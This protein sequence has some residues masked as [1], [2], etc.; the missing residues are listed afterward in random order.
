[1]HSKRAD[2][3]FEWASNPH[4]KSWRAALCEW[5][6]QH[7]SRIAGIKVGNVI[8]DRVGAMGDNPPS[9]EAY[10]RRSHTCTPPLHTTKRK[11]EGGLAFTRAVSSFFDWYLDTKLPELDD[12]GRPIWS[13]EHWNPVPKVRGQVRQTQTAREALPVRLIRQLLE[14]LTADDWRWAK[15]LKKDWITATDATTGEKVELWCP[16]RACALALKLLLPL[17]TFQ[18]RMLESSEGDSEQYRS[19]KWITNRSRHAPPTGRRNCVRRGFLRAFRNRHA[20]GEYTGFFVNTNKTANRIPDQA[21]AGYEIPWQHDHAIQIVEQLERWQ[22]RYNPVDQPLAWSALHEPLVRLATHP[23]P[24][25]AFFL[26]RDPNGTH[27]NEPVTDGRV[28]MLWNA[29]MAKCEDDLAQR[30]ER[31]PDG[32]P[33][34]LTE[35]RQ[36]TAR[37]RGGV[38]KKQSR[39]SIY[40]LHSLRVSLLTALAIDG[41]VPL[42]I[43]SKCIAGHASLVMTL[44]YVKTDPGAINQSL[45]DAEAKIHTGSQAAFLRYLQT[46][47]RSPD[48]CVADPAVLAAL[49][50][51]SPVSWQILETGICPVGGARCGDGGPPIGKNRFGPVPGGRNCVRCRFHISGPAFLPGIVAKFNACSMRVERARDHLEATQKLL[52]KAEDGQFDAEQQGA[53]GD[54]AALTRARDQHEAATAALDAELGTLQETAV[55]A[56]RCKK[57]LQLSDGEQPSLILKSEKRV[58]D[59]EIRKTS[60]FALYDAVCQAAELYPNEAVPEAHIRRAAALDRMLVRSGRAPVMLHL[61]DDVGLK[62]ANEFTRLMAIQ[63]GPD[64]AF[65]VITSERASLETDVAI[66]IDQTITRA[67]PP[68]TQE[69]SP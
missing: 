58:L 11:G 20:A 12:Q 46:Q 63:L 53:R 48:G 32:S 35:Y 52:T 37:Q 8:L 18:I 44:Y 17:R 62:V 27:P 4:L 31:L 54:P 29:L 59:A 19:G 25:T 39:C 16:V 60:S 22:E 57:I 24:G 51:T 9:V 66:L 68:P 6:S 23:R 15:A 2:P 3:A 43:L 21:E 61:P 45:R 38:E 64:R 1:V 49:G 26:M 47:T 41:G 34:R 50:N 56:E 10:C 65:E 33:I 28:E 67:L 30:G 69:T 42:H 40:D 55:L 14:V 36:V 5:V 13:A 7:S